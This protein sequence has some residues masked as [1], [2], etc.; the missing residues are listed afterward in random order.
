MKLEVKEVENEGFVSLEKILINERIQYSFINRTKP[1]RMIQINKKSL[2]V[3]LKR[4]IKNCK[5][6]YTIIDSTVLIH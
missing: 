4:V 1:D 2:T 3:W 5:A 6:N